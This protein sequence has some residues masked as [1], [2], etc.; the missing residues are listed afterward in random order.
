MQQLLKK[1][2]KLNISVSI[3]DAQLD[4]KA[5]KGSMTKELLSEI[6]TYKDELLSFL[7]DYSL[8]DIS[9]QIIRVEEKEHYPLSSSQYR[10]WLLQEIENNSSAYNMPSA[11]YIN[12]KLDV[13]ILE[14]SI[15]K[16]IEKHEILRTNFKVDEKIGEPVQFI[17]LRDRHQFKFEYLDYTEEKDTSLEYKRNGELNY[18]FDLENESL[19]RVTLI[20]SK[21][22]EYQLI[23]VLHHIISDA[24]SSNIILEELL[25]NY[26]QL[27]NGKT[28]NSSPLNIQYKDYAV[29]LEQQMKGEEFQKSERYWLTKFQGEIPVLELPGFKKRPHFKTYNGRTIIHRYDRDLLEKVEAFSLENKMTMFM[30]VLGIGKQ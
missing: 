12:G 25:S 4:V 5:P 10:L 23:F 17:H 3:K 7:N 9:S 27:L 22:E 29:W 1:L 6:K 26:K 30:T 11:Y 20:K 24:W 13:V 19:L 28:I 15:N 8:Q 16:L 2:N 14:E 21:E 18:A